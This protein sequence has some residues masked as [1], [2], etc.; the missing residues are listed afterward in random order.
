MVKKSVIKNIVKEIIE[1]REGIQFPVNPGSLEQTW[2]EVLNS[3]IKKNEISEEI[4][5]K[6][7]TRIRNS[8]IEIYL[9]ENIQTLQQKLEEN[10]KLELEIFSIEI[11]SKE[12]VNSFLEGINYFF[13]QSRQRLIDTIHLYIPTNANEMLTKYTLKLEDGIIETSKTLKPSYTSIIETQILSY[14]DQI[15]QRISPQIPNLLTFTS[16]EQ[17]AFVNAFID[18]GLEELKNYCNSQFS[19]FPSILLNLYQKKC[20]NS[21]AEMY[22]QARDQELLKLETRF[23]HFLNYVIQKI[24]TK[25]LVVFD[26]TMCTE[27]AR[28]ALAEIA[29]GLT[30]D[31]LKLPYEL[32]NDLLVFLDAGD[33]VSFYDHFRIH[34]EIERS[35][36]KFLSNSDQNARFFCLISL[37]LVLSNTHKHIIDPEISAY[38]PYSPVNR[39]W[40]R[41]IVYVAF[42]RKYESI[43]EFN[44]KFTEWNLVLI[45]EQN[46]INYLKDWKNNKTI[47]TVNEYLRKN[48]KADTIKEHSEKPKTNNYLKKA[49]QVSSRIVKSIT[50]NSH[51]DE[52]SFELINN[53]DS[54]HATIAISGWLSQEDEMQGAWSNLVNFKQQA[55]TFA[56]RWDSGTLKKMLKKELYLTFFHAVKL[57]VSSPMNK[58]IHLAGLLQS[59]PFKKRAKKAEITGN[60]LADTIIA[61]KLGNCCISLIG[62]SLGTRVIYY[63]LQRLQEKG[64]FVHDVILLGGAAPCDQDK[65]NLCRKAVTGRFVNNYSKTDKVLSLLYSLSKLE[66]AIGNWPLN[67]YNAENYDMTDIATGHLKYRET[68]DSILEKIGYNTK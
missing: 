13:E 68:L 26:K 34:D 28:V 43:L 15:V 8:T 20:K 11:A 16:K 42:Q 44:S 23:L 2:C 46:I 60:L 41:Q 55:N 67:V 30:P 64:Y 10:I 52:F 6:D 49:L 7:Y 36:D 3:S 4:T 18:Q 38:E 32:L 58:I 63:C 59:N 51:I 25:E 53:K 57:I 33:A 1:W 50:N 47:I 48:S 5:E 54:L 65:W 56:L 9:E 24:Q 14:V 61:K 27:N 31:S 22:M 62:F 45:T 37:V 40:I 35:V 29:L 19:N 21:I 39:E 12:S 66:K 17:Q